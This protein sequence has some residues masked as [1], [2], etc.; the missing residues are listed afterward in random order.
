MSEDKKSFIEKAWNKVQEMNAPYIEVIHKSVKIMTI[1]QLK[2]LI[3]ELEK[4]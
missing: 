1:T 4:K 3:K 2:K